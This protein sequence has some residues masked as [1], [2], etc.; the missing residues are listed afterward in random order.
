LAWKIGDFFE[1]LIFFRLA[2]KISATEFTTP[3]L[4][5]RLTPLPV[6]FS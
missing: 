6:S 3:R 1:N 5:T 4:R 2:S